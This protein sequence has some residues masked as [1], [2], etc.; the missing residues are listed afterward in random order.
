[1]RNYLMLFISILTLASCTKIRPDLKLTTNALQSFLT[2]DSVLVSNYVLINADET[3]NVMDSTFNIFAGGAFLDTV[4]WQPSKINAI[5]INDTSLNQRL[6][7]SRSIRYVG[8]KLVD[9]KA[10]YGTNVKVFVA[11]TSSTDTATRYIYMPKKVLRFTSDMPDVSLQDS[12]SF[13]VR[14]RKDTAT[15]WNNVVIQV[16][17]SYGLTKA[18][19]SDA[20]SSIASLQYVTEDDGSFTIPSGD[21]SNFGSNTFVRIIVGRGS[22]VNVELPISH[23]I[24]YIY[25][26]SSITSAPI[27]L[28]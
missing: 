10:M 25:T 18:H 23:K 20:P 19:R 14:W 6:D 15:D 22:T 13:T 7:S 9:G 27:L 5:K 12:S 21:M 1:M 3:A 16:D 26:I 11:G 4:N 24:V 17:Y 8:D 28:N 2:G